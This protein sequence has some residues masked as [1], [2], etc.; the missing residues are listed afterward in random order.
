MVFDYC[1]VTWAT[2]DLPQAMLVCHEGLA[3]GSGG[4]ADPTPGYWQ[5]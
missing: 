4:H 1:D 3:F 5:E 2:S